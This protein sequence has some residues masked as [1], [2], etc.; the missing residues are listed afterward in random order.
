VVRQ[1]F[2]GTAVSLFGGSILSQPVLAE[3]LPS[4]ST[5]GT[6]TL[7]TRDFPALLAVGG[8]V[9]LNVGLSHPLMLTRAAENRVY[10][11]SSKCQHA[12]CVV[13]AYDPAAGLIVC[14]CHGSTYGVD[15]TL[16]GGPAERSLP[17][18]QI[19]FDGTENIAV[20]LPGLTFAARQ[21][22]VQSITTE[23]RRLR[24]VFN[25]FLANTYQ[26]QFRAE[27]NHPPQVIPFSLTANG[28][29][30]HLSYRNLSLVDPNPTI[31]LYVDQTTQTGFYQIILVAT[32]F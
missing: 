3:D 13:N 24:L 10:A 31:S 7:K 21:I 23:A 26:I 32:E 5:E 4:D 9:L 14:G 29:A 8:S 12:G 19:T 6:L 16:V 2:L 18:F 17:S 22:A 28:P 1:L 27:L 15:G 11:L 20:R 25:P 30:S